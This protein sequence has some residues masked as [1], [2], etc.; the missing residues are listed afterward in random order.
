MLMVQ[1]HNVVSTSPSMEERIGARFSMRP[2][3]LAFPIW[4]SVP[5]THKFCLP[6]HGIPIVLPGAPML[7]SMDPAVG[8]TALKMPAKRG[9][10][11]TAADYP[12]AIGHALP[13]DL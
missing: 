1:T 4:Q 9:P 10:A 6:A 5:A 7:P 13:L 2:P 3:R 11:S 8:S 12:K